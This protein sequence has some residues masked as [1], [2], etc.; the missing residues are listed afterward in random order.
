MNLLS[1]LLLLPLMRLSPAR[2]GGEPQRAFDPVVTDADACERV[3]RDMLAQVAR[4]EGAEAALV[5][6]RV[7]HALD[8][9][10]LWHLRSR[11]M[12]LLAAQHGESD[13]RRSLAGVDAVIREHW[14]DAPVSRPAPLH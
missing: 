11:L 8:M 7:Q 12:Q 10:S 13:A 1:N 14:P 2:R 4:C 9:A 6:L 3:R 5:R